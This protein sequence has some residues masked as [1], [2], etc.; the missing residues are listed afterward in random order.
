E[1]IITNDFL[2]KTRLPHEAPGSLAWRRLRKR[3][4]YYSPCR[5]QVGKKF[6]HIAAVCRNRLFLTHPVRF[7]IFKQSL[8]R[9]GIQAGSVCSIVDIFRFDCTCDSFR[10]PLKYYGGITSVITNYYR[11]SHLKINDTCFFKRSRTESSYG[12]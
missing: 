11:L 2:Q 10:Q 8:R 12:Y 6:A 4:D 7:T 3:I 1:Q 5:A 9:T